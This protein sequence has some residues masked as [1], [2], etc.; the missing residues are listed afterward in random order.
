LTEGNEENEG[1]SGPAPIGVTGNPPRRSPWLA[2]AFIEGGS[3]QARLSYFT[4][5]P[6]NDL[7]IFKIFC[8]AG[9]NFPK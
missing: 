5:Q 8:H 6:F 3:A 7:T 2:G 1:L 4:L 9:K